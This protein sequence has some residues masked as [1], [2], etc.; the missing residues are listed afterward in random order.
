VA[1]ETTEAVT[2]RISSAGVWRDDGS[3][4]V[5]AAARRCDLLGH[6]GE[7]V[8]VRDGVVELP[9]RPWEIATIQLGGPDR[10]S[11]AGDSDRATTPDDPGRAT[12][13]RG[14]VSTP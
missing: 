8:P 12:T 13:A 14:H 6:P 2:A 4:V 1:A 5:A 9:L 11:S 10:T 7:E 3:W